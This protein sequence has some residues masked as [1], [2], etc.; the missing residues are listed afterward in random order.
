L[1]NGGEEGGK[2]KGTARQKP[3]TAIMLRCVHTR[4]FLFTILEI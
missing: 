3:Y 2:G 1:G 4:V